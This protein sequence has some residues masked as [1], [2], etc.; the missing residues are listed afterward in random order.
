MGN[1]AFGK[2]KWEGI[3]IGYKKCQK[4]QKE[5]SLGDLLLEIILILVELFIKK[6]K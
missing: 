6:I 4:E 3:D 2:G 1:K 5:K